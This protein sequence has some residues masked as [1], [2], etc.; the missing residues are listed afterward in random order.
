MERSGLLR[1]PVKQRRNNITPSQEGDGED[2]LGPQDR[3][4]Q[5]I[6]KRDRPMTAC[7]QKK[8]RESKSWPRKFGRSLWKRTRR[9]AKSCRTLMRQV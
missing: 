3:E 7:W 6:D 2:H 8:M 9:G 5:D 4:A 1:R